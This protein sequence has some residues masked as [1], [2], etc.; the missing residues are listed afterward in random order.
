MKRRLR[1]FHSHA[2]RSLWMEQQAGHEVIVRRSNNTVEMPNVV[3]S[4]YLSSE[5]HMLQGLRFDEVELAEYVE[6]NLTAEARAR[7]SYVTQ[8]G[9]YR[10]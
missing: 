6:E 7:L 5:I 4:C 1:I 10:K 2:Q 9:G 3:V 8:S